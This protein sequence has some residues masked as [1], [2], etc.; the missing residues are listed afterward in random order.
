MTPNSLAPTQVEVAMTSVHQIAQFSFSSGYL[1]A[2]YFLEPQVVQ[3]QAVPVC[4]RVRG[5]QDAGLSEPKPGQ[6]QMRGQLGTQGPA[7]G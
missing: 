4:L 1:L 3:P 5:S 7:K 2:S 6:S